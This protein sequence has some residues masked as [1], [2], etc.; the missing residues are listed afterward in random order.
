MKSV[1]TVL[2]HIILVMM[3]RILKLILPSIVL[4]G[5]PT[6]PESEG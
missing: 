3:L 1:I 5:T 2:M 6:G 4:A